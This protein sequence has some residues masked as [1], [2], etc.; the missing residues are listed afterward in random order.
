NLIPNYSFG[1]II[2]ILLSLFGWGLG[3]FGL[4]HIVTKF[5]GIKNVE[6]M[7]KSKWDGISWQTIA[8]GAATLIG[9]VA[10]LFYPQGIDNSELVFINMVTSLFPT[11]I[12]AF[13]L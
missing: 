13:I 10:V 1:T 6:D 3:Y 11:F 12:A 4:P 7:P 8:L 5:M 9:V 2:S